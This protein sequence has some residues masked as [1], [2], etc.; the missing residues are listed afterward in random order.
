M[1]MPKPRRTIEDS[2]L[3]GQRNA[4]GPVIAIPVRLFAVLMLEFVEDLVPRFPIHANRAR[5]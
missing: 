4:V 5:D 3:T 1:A 2:S